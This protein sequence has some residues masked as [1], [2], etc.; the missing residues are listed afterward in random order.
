MF[1]VLRGDATAGH[2]VGLSKAWGRV[3]KRAG[4]DGVRLH[5]LRHSFASFAV[6]GGESLYLIGK[7]LGHSHATMTERYAHLADDPVRAAAERTAAAIQRAAGRNVA[8][9]EQKREEG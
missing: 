5:D 8:A 6:A 1:P 2:T 9:V 3:R 7:A 4:L